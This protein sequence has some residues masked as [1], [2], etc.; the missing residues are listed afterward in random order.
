MADQIVTRETGN[1]PQ[2]N[3]PRRS[4]T[5]TVSFD[6]DAGVMRSGE[7]QAPGGKAAA[8][9][10]VAALNNAGVEAQQLDEHGA[11]IAADA[12]VEPEGEFTDDPPDGEQPDLEA[13][14]ADGEAPDG[15]PEADAVPEPAA[16]AWEV[17]NL[18]G[19]LAEAHRRLDELQQ[20]TRTV[21]FGAYFD[22][23]AGFL[24]AKVAEALG[25]EVDDP[26]IKEEWRS[27]IGEL[28]LDGLALQDLPQEQ[29]AQFR[30]DRFDRKIKL[31]QHRRQAEQRASQVSKAEQQR[32]QMIQSVIDSSSDRFKALPIAEQR[33]GR[34]AWIL[35]RDRLL[36]GIRAG[37]I[38]NW[39]TRDTTELLQEATRL[40]DSE[41]QQWARSLSPRLAHLSSATAPAAPGASPAPKAG[42]RAEPS[43]GAASKK[44]GT[45]TAKPRTLPNAQAGAAPSRPGAAQKPAQPLSR[46]PDVRRRQVMAKYNAKP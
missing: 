25:V 35:V 13:A 34:P 2:G 36:Q 8:L 37:E 30:A 45:N 17:Q 43:Q 44:T 26:S 10:R 39:E 1:Q 9:A 46:D 3:Q 18:R 16:P 41:S 27:L 29:Q 38:R 14:P 6:N 22:D 20:N 31:D 40:V 11:P 5:V 32:Q 23:P 42:Q 4:P 33:F 7:A 24:R 15:E 12:G 28:T 19:E 21:N